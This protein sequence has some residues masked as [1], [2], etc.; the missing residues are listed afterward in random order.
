MPLLRLTFWFR[1]YL[2]SKVGSAIWNKYCPPGKLIN[3]CSLC[4]IRLLILCRELRQGDDNISLVNV[5]NQ[6]T[7]WIL[8]H[9]YC[10]QSIDSLKIYA[11]DKIFFNNCL[12]RNSILPKAKRSI[13]SPQPMRLTIS[14]INQIKINSKLKYTQLSNCQ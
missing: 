6:N 4:S 13:F 12:N 7:R 14:P 1:K 11:S 2:H 10:S 8:L 3:Q 5:R 9:F